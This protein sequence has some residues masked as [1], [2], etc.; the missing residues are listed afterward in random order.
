LKF[1][2]WQSKT[3]F[4]IPSVA[5]LSINY[6]SIKNSVALLF[7]FLS[8]HAYAISVTDFLG[9]TV[10]LQAPAKRIVA[11]APHIVENIYTAGGGDAVIAVVDY[12]DFPEAART[13]PS[14]GTMGTFSLETI[15]NLQPDLVVIWHTGKSGELY[16]K[17]IALGMN[18]YASAPHSLKDIS[19]S[20]RD[21]GALTG[22]S[23]VA[24]KN[25]LN[26]ERELSKI[27]AHYI[28]SSPVNSF[29]QVWNRPILTINGSSIISDVMHLCGGVNVFGDEPSVVPK[30]SVESVISAN[31]SAI[32]AS[33]IA[34][35]RPDWLDDWKQWPSIEAVKKDN[36]FF[37]PPD[38]IQRH[39]VR[40]LDGAK[41]MCE[42]MNE[43]RR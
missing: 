1:F 19:K 14:L 11:L 42:Q 26:F 6:L 5:F 9:N 20:I 33:G 28:S 13:L 30:L 40:I 27:K 23:N 15:V 2:S 43:A 38:I 8:A 12:S 37:V 24:E 10:S 41:M 29:Y 4:N 21:F 7:L 35:E 31:P 32:F 22:Y 3:A 16:K 39:S 34:N 36:L 17:L 25:A 18:T